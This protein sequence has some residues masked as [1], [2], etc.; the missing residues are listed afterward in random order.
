MVRLGKHS[1][2]R[3]I[4]YKVGDLFPSLSKLINRRDV[5]E[6]LT[7]SK[8]SHNEIHRKILPLYGEETVDMSTEL[9]RNNK[10]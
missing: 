8:E 5:M 9:P 3:C 10:S 4:S 1:G 2:L 7:H 6:F